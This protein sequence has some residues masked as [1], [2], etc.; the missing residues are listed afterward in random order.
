MSSHQFYKYSIHR[1][2]TKAFV[3]IIPENERWRIV[4]NG[5][6][7]EDEEN[8]ASN[9]DIYKTRH[10]DTVVQSEIKTCENIKKWLYENCIIYNEN[11]KYNKKIVKNTIQ[12]GDMIQLEWIEYRNDGSYFWDGENVIQLEYE[13]DDYGSIPFEFSFPEFPFT[14]FKD[15]IVH[16]NLIQLSDKLMNEVKNNVKFDNFVNVF[17]E[18]D[19]EK[20]L[21]CNRG[22]VYSSFQYNNVTYNIIGV[23]DSIIYDNIQGSNMVQDYK[24]VPLD[25][26][27]NRFIKLFNKGLNDRY[28]TFEW[29][30]LSTV[31][32]NE[33]VLF[34]IC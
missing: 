22:I 27:K 11:K 6:Y 18:I 20:Y 2:P 17:P 8:I 23:P 4:N 15:R 30:G 34:N 5:K 33:N 24:N 1:D 25:D 10:K 9:I 21:N 3:F 12:R 29:E 7:L 19:G 28:I 26:F 13:I 16:N 14:Y 32:S 31:F